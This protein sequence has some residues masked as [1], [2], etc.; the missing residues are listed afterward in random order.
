MVWGHGMVRGSGR[1]ELCFFRRSGERVFEGGVDFYGGWGVESFAKGGASRF[2]VEGRR[3]FLGGGRVRAGGG[4][5]IFFGGGGGLDR[6][7]DFYGDRGVES[8][9]KSGRFEVEG[10]RKE[11]V[12][13]WAGD[14]ERVKAGGGVFWGVGGWWRCL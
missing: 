8:F 10:R 1:V 6:G 5:F 3:C 12:S 14:R 2:R 4:V 13:R 9:A 11:V 7:V